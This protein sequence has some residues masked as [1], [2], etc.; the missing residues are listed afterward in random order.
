MH[1]SH[2]LL[3]TVV[4]TINILFIIVYTFIS[5]SCIFTCTILTYHFLLFWVTSTWIIYV[6]LILF[7]VPKHI[8]ML[9]KEDLKTNTFDYVLND[10]YSAI[11]FQLKELVSKPL[12]MFKCFRHRENVFWWM[13]IDHRS[14]IRGH[15]FS[16]YARIWGIFAF[17][18]LSCVPLRWPS[19]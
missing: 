4:F 3:I 7:S 5:N 2:D 12:H 18:L 17:R 15:P 9:S 10:E 8:H 19:G 1:I 16:M 6:S 14:R 11:L 13:H